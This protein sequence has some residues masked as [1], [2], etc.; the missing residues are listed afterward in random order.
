ME[1]QMALF[2]M[3][4][5]DESTIWPQLPGKNQREIE[6]LFSKLLIKFLSST[7]YEVKQHAKK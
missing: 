5:K 2:Q 1:K 4:E 7:S 6:N 3:E